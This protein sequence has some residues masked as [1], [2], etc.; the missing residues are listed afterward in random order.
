MYASGLYTTK[1]K[2]KN[3]VV[4]DVCNNVGKKNNRLERMS[5]NETNTAVC[6]CDLC[7]VYSTSNSAVTLTTDF[8]PDFLSFSLQDKSQYADERCD[9]DTMNDGDDWMMIKMTEG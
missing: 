3:L 9:E 8:I 2:V 6:K 1:I 5:F 4:S 7:V